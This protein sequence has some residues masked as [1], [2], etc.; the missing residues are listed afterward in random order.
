MAWGAT[1]IKYM[2]ARAGVLKIM[3]FL[4]YQVDIC[5]SFSKLH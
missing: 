1:H 5:K 2:S 3:V 4:L